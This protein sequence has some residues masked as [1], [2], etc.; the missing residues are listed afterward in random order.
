[1]HICIFEDKYYRNFL[2]LVYFRPVYH[3]H[4][5]ALSLCQKIELIAPR[6]K[7]VYQMRSMLV[8]SISE[9]F[10]KLM[11]NK[12]PNDDVWFINGRVLGDEELANLIKSHPK[13]QKVYIQGDSVAAAFV[14]KENLPG[15]LSKLSDNLVEESPFKNI[16]TDL[17][18]GI[19]F[20]YPWDLVNNTAE[21]I[22]KDFERLKQKKN[23]FGIV[24][25]GAHL[26]NK[27][28]IIIGKGSAI[29]PGVV[30]DAERGSIIIGEN[31]TIMPNAVVEGPVF[32]GDN[33][34]I[35]I[36]AKI[37]HG[38]SIGKW[39]KVGGEVEASIIQS[40]TNK[41][42]DGFLGHSYLGSWVNI[43]A[44]TNTSDLKNNYSTVRVHVDGK[45]IDSGHQ[46][47]GLTMGDHSKSGINTMFDTGT[48]IGI[49][50]NIYGSGFHPKFI[51]SFAWGGEN[52]FTTYNLEKSIDTM[53]R[54][55]LRR[56]VK[57]SNNYEKLV[58]NV[59]INTKQDRQR[60][61][62]K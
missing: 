25:V 27:K 47:V 36:G 29:K 32:I 5:G 60:A 49:S 21:K 57:M 30:L 35:K 15:L 26:L 50:S 9:R 41:Q 55:M 39:C 48:V 56:N 18:P 58:R 8:E 31:V 53:K 40:Y 20:N 17:F 61:G 38:T 37:Y 3:L 1:M 52:Q 28:K 2:P 44:D 54:V 62:V 12:I 42:H 10:P 22:D 23:I 16:P 51:P 45:I 4:C 14:K 33:S 43:G 24:D 7:T 19:I 6:I 59:F 13:G 46:F 34:T 11:I